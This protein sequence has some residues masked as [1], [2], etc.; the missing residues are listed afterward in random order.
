MKIATLLLTVSLFLDGWAQGPPSFVPYN[1][2]NPVVKKGSAGTWDSGTVLLPCVTVV[3]DT[4]YMTYFGTIDYFSGDFSIGLAIST[5]G[6]YTFTKSQANP[7]LTPDGEGFDSGS[8]TNGPLYF[9]EGTWYLYYCGNQASSQPGK[10]ISVAT[11]NSPHGPWTRTN[12]TLLTTGSSGEW[13]GHF[14]LPLQI[15]YVDT[16]IFLYYWAGIDFVPNNLSAQIGRAVS[17]DNG[18]TWQKYD[19]PATTDPPYAESDPVLKIGASYDAYSTFG[20]GIIFRGNSWEMCYIGVAET[21][22]GGACWATSADGFNW[23]KNSEYNPFA[24]N[25]NDPWA[26]YGVIESFSMLFTDHHY[27][28]YY[29]YGPFGD[30]IGLSWADTVDLVEQISE[31]RPGIFTLDQNYPNPFNPATTIEFQIPKTDFVLLT[32]YNSLGQPMAEPVRE[33]L[34]PG[35]YKVQWDASGLASGVYYCRLSGQT[36]F[37]QTRKLLFLK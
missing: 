25:F 4:I 35:R 26:I 7:I 16:E 22:S 17:T 36:G 13:D 21:G 32:I 10:I 23:I 37:T 2:G 24:S 8:L 15:F 30:G 14:L 3:N 12:D 19:D 1:E 9:S 6:G 20:A 18:K 27:F 34:R 11:A 29:D 5:D 33:K 28:L 31:V